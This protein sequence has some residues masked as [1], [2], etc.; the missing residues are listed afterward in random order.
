MMIAS[1]AAEP[2]AVR[3]SEGGLAALHIVDPTTH[4]GWD[5]LL[6]A[7]SDATFFHSAA[8]AKTLVTAY[9]F[10]CRYIAALE[11]G[12]MRALLPLM[13]AASWM[14]G[15]RGVSLPFTDECSPLLDRRLSPDSLL[16]AAMHEGE[17]RGWKYLELRGGHDR[18]ANLP[19]SISFY[20][21][22]L[23][24]DSCA[25]NLF[26]KFDSSVRRAIRKAERSGVTVECRTDLEAVRAYYR[27]HCRTRTKHGAPPQPFSF[28]RALWEHALQRGHGFVALA[29]HEGRPIAAALF[30]QFG[31]KAIYKFS[32]SDERFQ[33]LRGANLIIWQVVQ[34]LVKEGFTELNF[35]KTSRSN[36][37]L[38]HFKRNWAA[39]ES[40]VHYARYCFA[41]RMFVKMGD[42]AAGVQARIFARMPVFLSC[43]IGRA[44]YPHMS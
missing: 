22:V 14:R 24:L 27:L 40:L 29:I 10:Q 1:P 33:E 2:A 37:G 28:F 3:P 21:H 44:V 5:G 31:G 15:R 18:L 42:L 8:W 13:E 36:E 30:L 19:E 38:R 7:H 11:G 25:E 12:K 16:Q 41:R 23:R 17:L 4:A 39:D 32:A 35:G 6:E 43:W 9:R 26:A 34:K 20:S